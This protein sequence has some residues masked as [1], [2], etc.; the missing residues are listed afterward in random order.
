L[1]QLNTYVRLK[2]WK[3][4][5]AAQKYRQK[6]G[7]WPNKME[8]GKYEPVGVEVTNFIKHLNIKYAKGK[9]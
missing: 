3:E 7:V 9:G 8:E 2:G 1:N 5:Y 6:F 4:G